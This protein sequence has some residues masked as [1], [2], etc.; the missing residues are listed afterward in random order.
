MAAAAE[1]DDVPAAP[2]TGVLGVLVAECGRKVRHRRSDTHDN[3]W[4]VAAGCGAF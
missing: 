3:L 1:R 2:R 4:R